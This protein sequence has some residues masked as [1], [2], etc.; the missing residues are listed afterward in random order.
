[1]IVMAQQIILSIMCLVLTGLSL[2]F[3][4]LWP[5]IGAVIVFIILV[6]TLVKLNCEDE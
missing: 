2:Y 6:E 4:S 1:M 5:A 3:E